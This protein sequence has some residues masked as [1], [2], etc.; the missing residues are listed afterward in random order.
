MKKR[1]CGEAEVARQIAQPADQPNIANLLP[2]LCE[3]AEFQHGLSARF[4]LRQAG[5]HEI[6]HTAVNV[7]LQFAL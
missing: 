5:L 7:V 2:E 3:P 4:G 6:V 1:T